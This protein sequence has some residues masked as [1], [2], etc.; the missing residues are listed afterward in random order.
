MDG[1]YD[2]PDGDFVP[3]YLDLDS[4][5]DGLD[6]NEEDT[7]LNG[8]LD[9]G[10]TNPLNRDTDLDGLDDRLEREAGYDPRSTDSDGDEIPDNV[11]D[12]NRDGVLDDNETDPTKSDTDGDGLA[13]GEEDVNR[14][15]VVD[16]GE[17]DP[18]NA[19]TDGDF[20]SDGDQ[21]VGEDVAAGPDNCPLIDNPVVGGVQADNDNDGLG[22]ACDDDIDGDTIDNEDDFCPEIS[23]A[24]NLNSDDADDGGDVCDDDDDNDGLTD[25]EEEALGT[26][27][28]LADTDN[29]TV[30]DNVDNCPLVVN[31]AQLNTDD[32]LG[33]GDEFG[34]ACDDNDDNDNHLDV[35]D[36]CPLVPN[37]DQLDSDDDGEGDACDGDIDGDG[38]ANEDDLCGFVASLTNSD[39]DEDTIGDVCDDDMDGDGVNNLQANGNVLDLCPLTPILNFGSLGLNRNVNDSGCLDFD[40]DGLSYGDIIPGEDIEERFI[41]SDPYGDS[42]KFILEGENVRMSFISE[43]RYDGV[44][45]DGAEGSREIEAD[46]GQTRLF[47]IEGRMEFDFVKPPRFSEIFFELIDDRLPAQLKIVNIG[48]M[49]GNLSKMFEGLGD[50]VELVFSDGIFADFTDV[51]NYDRMFAGSDLGRVKFEGF[52]SWNDF[53]PKSARGMFL[54]ATF[55]GKALNFKDPN[56][57]SFIRTLDDGFKM[58]DSLAFAFGGGARF[59][60]LPD[61]FSVRSAEGMFSRARVNTV[62]NLSSID[63]ERFEGGDRMFSDMQKRVGGRAVRLMGVDLVPFLSSDAS[64]VLEDAPLILLEDSSLVNLLRRNGFNG[65]VLC[66]ESGRGCQCNVSD[67]IFS[68]LVEFS[69][70]EENVLTFLAECSIRN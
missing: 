66:K 11:E 41:D 51:T 68:R 9:E 19:D 36:S 33:N 16:S 6:D 56:D 42:E 67:V 44:L 63:S 15:G 58:F 21:N 48:Y 27:R 37:N 40:N 3:N 1:Y 29:D 57:L 50:S 69:I 22:D 10:E 54:S 59:I 39:Y 53:L 60:V 7:K 14:N 49:R 20:V 17:T 47:D 32:D 5:G 28:I 62:L 34:N 13:D 55:D 25:A 24:D 12:A 38:F 26:S 46:E 52:I 31:Q 45:S 2:G 4:D 61:N 43:D 8:N 35:D 70:I 18:R 23:N 30:R 64:A 65:N